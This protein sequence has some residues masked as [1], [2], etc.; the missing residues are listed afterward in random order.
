ME[1]VGKEP[2]D[3]HSN[4]HYSIAGRHTSSGG[5]VKLANPWDDFHVYAMEWNSERMDF[6]CD[7][8]KYFTFNLSKADDAGTNP[9][10]KPQYLLLNLALGGGYGGPIDDENLPQK[11]VD[12]LRPRLPAGRGEVV[13]HAAKRMEF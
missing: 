8:A 6:F 5:S 7:R 9:Y 11:F 10:R 2:H 1:Y 4:L 3:V 12:R 13:R